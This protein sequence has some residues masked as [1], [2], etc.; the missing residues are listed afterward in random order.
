MRPG[1]VRAPAWPPLAPAAP[2]GSGISIPFRTRRRRATPAG[3]HTSRSSRISGSD[4]QTVT[5]VR[6]TARLIARRTR[7]PRTPS[8][9]RSRCSP[10]VS[11]TDGRRASRRPVSIAEVSPITCTRSAPSTAR[12]S[13]RRPPAMAS[14]ARPAVRSRVRWRRRCSYPPPARSST[15]ISASPPA[16]GVGE[17]VEKAGHGQR[18]ATGAGTTLRALLEGRTDCPA[19]GGDRLEP[20][21]IHGVDRLH[22]TPGDFSV[23]RCVRCGNRS[24]PPGRRPGGSGLLLPLGLRAVR[25]AGQSPGARGLA[26]DPRTPGPAGPQ[27][28]ASRAAAGPAA[29]PRDRRGLRPRRPGRGAGGARLAGDRSGALGGRL[30]RGRRPRGARAAGNAG[31]RGAGARRLRRGGVPALAGARDR[32][33]GGPARREPRAPARRPRVRHRAQLRLV[34]GAPLRLALVPPRPAAP[35]RALHAAGACAPPWRAPAWRWWTSTR[36]AARWD[37]PPASNTRSP[38]AACSPTAWRFAWLSGSA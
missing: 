12:A 10:W 30:R 33:G 5:A 6:A 7:A 34:A 36:P 23:E 22:R 18:E 19:C 13:S 17:D 4:A 28:H 24:H 35:P 29:L 27:G 9:R 3:E 14:A 38:G 2:M 37:C 8:E 26:P 25:A 11:T 1:E 31:R 16:A 15:S 32:A 21:V 20:A